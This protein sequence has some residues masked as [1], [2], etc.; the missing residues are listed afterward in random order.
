MG[1]MAL[2]F[3]FQ[4]SNTMP[5]H[6]LLVEPGFV[7]QETLYVLQPQCQLFSSR[8]ISENF[9]GIQ[10]ESGKFYFCTVFEVVNAQFN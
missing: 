7:P 8:N 6:V 5:A 9:D 1:G 2:N 4:G 10:L 3:G